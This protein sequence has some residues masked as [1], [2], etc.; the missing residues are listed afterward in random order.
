MNINS[1]YKVFLSTTTLLCSMNAAHADTFFGIYLG[2]GTWESGFTGSFTTGSEVID[3]E[4]DLGFET[5]R[6]NFMYAAVEHPLPLIPNILISQTV[7]EHNASGALSRDITFLNTTYTVTENVDSVV[8]L[9]FSD[10]T[11]YYEI[12]DNW[13]SLDLG[14]SARQFD[15]MISISSNSQTESVEVDT[16][17]PMLYAYTRINLPFTGLYASGRLYT[18]ALDGNSINDL[19][20]NI[21]YESM[22]G[23]GFEIGYREI[24]FGIEDIDSLNTDISVQGPYAAATF[25]F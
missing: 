4:Q 1:F 24:S 9:T 18:V 23:A 12:L 8:D 11:F 19:N 2:A 3:L 21:G 22:L 20:V 17:A 5:N 10:A 16:I 14:I 7:V 13:I 25:H 6:N 15:G